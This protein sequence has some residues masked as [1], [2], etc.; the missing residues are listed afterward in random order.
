[1]GEIWQQPQLWPETAQRVVAASKDWGDFVNSAQAILLTGSGSSYFVG[2]C[3]A[4][5]LQESTSVPV[6]A[7]ESGEILM[8]GDGALPPARPLLVVS[9]ARS[10]DS[11]ESWGLVQHLLDEEPGINH[12]LI[13]CNPNGR[14]A[15]MWGERGTDRD[16]RVKVLVM[17]ERCCDRSL[18]MTSS[19]T[20]MA[21]AGL[22]LAFPGPAANHYL[23][24]VEALAAS[25]ANLLANLLGPIE[26]FPLEK[27][28]RMIAVGSGALHGAALEVSLKML[29]MSDGRVLTRS[30][31]C[32]GLRH[33]PMCALHSRSLLFLPL[34]SHPLRRAYQM[35]LLKEVDRKRLGGWKVVVGG[36]IPADV[37]SPGDLALE[38]AGLAGLGDEWVAI[39]SVV[40]GQL[41]AFL[42]C[43]VEGLRPDEPA[44][45]DSITRVVGNFTLHN[46]SAGVS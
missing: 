19:F 9:F 10:G 5:A 13:T 3:I 21:V 8:L 11:P 17:D 7:L 37:L 34:S 44:V 36:D 20:S 12:L 42:R 4:T 16:P 41:L 29:E 28:E 26:E 14:L 25:V 45:S 6:T 30:E 24:T 35:D 38:M 39:A 27:V 1:M 22:G 33:G 46:L 40:V 23:E 32:L 43:R 15:R 2:K 31:G 18:V